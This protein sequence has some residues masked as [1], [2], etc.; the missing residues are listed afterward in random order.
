MRETWKCVY[1]IE[2]NKDATQYRV[3]SEYKDSGNIYYSIVGSMQDAIDAVNV[4]VKMDE[5]SSPD[6]LWTAIPF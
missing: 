5:D 3:V 2:A 1:T 4:R 6:N